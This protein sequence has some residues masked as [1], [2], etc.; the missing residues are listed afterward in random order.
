MLGTSFHASLRKNNFL[1]FFFRGFEEK[2]QFF[3]SN[4]LVNQLINTTLLLQNYSFKRKWFK[5]KAS[6]KSFKGGV[7]KSF[8][9]GVSLLNLSL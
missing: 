4:P 5:R 3:S 9:G 2:T 6:I 1:L 7:S 8:K